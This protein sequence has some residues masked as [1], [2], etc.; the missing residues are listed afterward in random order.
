VLRG[1]RHCERSEFLV[2]DP[3]QVLTARESGIENV[4]AIL[5]EN[6]TALRLE[7]LAALMDER[8]CEHLEIS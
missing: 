6:V 3:L 5:T 7:R 1:V 2:R 4:V 8:K